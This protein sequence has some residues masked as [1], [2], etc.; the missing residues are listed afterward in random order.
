MLDVGYHGG[1]TVAGVDIVLLNAGVAA[2]GE[3]GGSGAIVADGG[4]AIGSRHS[5]IRY[6]FGADVPGTS[7]AVAGGVST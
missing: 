4:N 3:E 5:L 7:L 1:W 2:N 6:S